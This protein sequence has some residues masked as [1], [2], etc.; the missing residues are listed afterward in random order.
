[1]FLS[2]VSVAGFN[3]PVRKWHEPLLNKQC[4]FVLWNAGIVEPKITIFACH[5]NDAQEI[6][7]R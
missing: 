7:T 4:I 1:V 6:T 3:F 2:N 5:Q